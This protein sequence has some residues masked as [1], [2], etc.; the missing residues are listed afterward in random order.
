VVTS[1]EDLLTAAQGGDGEA[2]TMFYRRHVSAVSAFHRR[3][4]ASAEVA[5]DLTAETF[6]SLVAALDGFD[7]VRGSAR[8]WLFAI[9]VNELRQ[10]LRRQRVEDRA[11]RHLGLDPIALSDRALEHVDARGS[12][13]EFE[14]AL[15]D[16][17][18]AER[19][20]IELRILEELEYAEIAERV[21]CSQA[22]IR[23][24]V[25]RG[26]RRLRRVADAEELA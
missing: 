22:V 4:V 17:P 3:R 1:D 18:A 13:G 7:P 23:Q 15:G 10:A 6:A 19:E 2:F 24:R 20:A 25:S 9:A 16:L 5:F 11:R 26:L 21:R 14:Q 8:G 12:P